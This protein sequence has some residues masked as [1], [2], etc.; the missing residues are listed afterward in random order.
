VWV[1]WPLVWAV[2]ECACA[3]ARGLAR[4]AP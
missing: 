1:Q 2:A 3:R 4:A